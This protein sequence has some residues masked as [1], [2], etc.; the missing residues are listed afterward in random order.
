MVYVVRLA[1]LPPNFPV[2]TAAAVAV[3][4]IMHNMAPST[5][6]CPGRCGKKTSSKERRAKLPACNNNNHPC[7]R[8]GR[9]SFGFTL[10]KVMNNMVKISAGCR[11]AT[12]FAT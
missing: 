10:Q 9:K 7:Q 12:N 8:V 1:A 5:N 4:H 2:T 11:N 6:T 3:G